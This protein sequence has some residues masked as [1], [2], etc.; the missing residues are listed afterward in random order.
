LDWR[1]ILLKQQQHVQQ[2]EQAINQN[3]TVGGRREL[4]NL[5]AAVCGK[6]P[7]IVADRRNSQTAVTEVQEILRRTES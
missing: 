3:Q 5:D 2:Q 4:Q 6:D 7:P 1:Y